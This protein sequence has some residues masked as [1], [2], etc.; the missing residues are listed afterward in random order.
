MASERNGSYKVLWLEEASAHIAL[1]SRA[2]VL[3]NAR[4][5]L[6]SVERDLS[7]GED[8]PPDLRSAMCYADR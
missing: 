4:A 7:F 3:G 6:S 8:F 1:V 5:K 2:H